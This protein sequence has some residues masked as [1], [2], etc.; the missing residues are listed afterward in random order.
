MSPHPR[1]AIVCCVTRNWLPAAAV[2]LLS[3]V[4]RGQATTIDLLICAHGA[5]AG[6][7]QSLQRFNE[8]HGLAIRLIEVDAVGQERSDLGRF[9]MGTLIRLTLD[10]YI[11]ATYERILYLDAD[12]LVAEDLAPLIAADLT[13]HTLG[14]VQDIG[15]ITAVRQKVAKHRAELGL[16]DKEPYFNAGVLLFDWQAALQRDALGRARAMLASRERWGALDQD[17][18][19]MALRGEW[20]A[21]DYKWNVTALIQHNSD[22][23]PAIFHFTASEKPWSAKRLLW[24]GRFHAFYKSSLAGTG[25]ESFVERRDFYALVR[26]TGESVRKSLQFR[27]RTEV[28]KILDDAARTA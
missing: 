15:I 7:I 19:N 10:R 22:I 16:A 14:A 23:R 17:A 1:T 20:L 18:L 24:H 11:D 9:G 27:Q 6:D 2:A 5:S 12:V 28:A 3:C 26:A 8:T 25:W 4:T 13:S 21:L